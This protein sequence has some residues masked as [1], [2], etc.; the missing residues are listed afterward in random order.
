[1][2][3]KLHVVVHIPDIFTALYHTLKCIE[4]N[5]SYA[6]SFLLIPDYAKERSGIRRATPDQLLDVYTKVKKEFPQVKVGVNF[7]SSGFINDGLLS[8]YGFDFMQSDGAVS[9]RLAS[10]FPGTQFFAGLAFKYSKYENARGDDLKKLCDEYESGVSNL[11]PT[12]SGS[13]TGKEADL[14]KIKEI[15]KYLPNGRLAIAS[16]VT[17]LNVSSYLRLGV[18]DFI[19]ATSLIES[20]TEDGFDIISRV[21]TKE[22]FE[23]IF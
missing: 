10:S 18:T 19:V 7:L 8:E 16:G 21:K 2:E 1:M 5:H 9:K 23:Q 12:T 17:L 20:V 14:S 6:D 13:A 4:Q 3:N 22:L 15:R 11:I